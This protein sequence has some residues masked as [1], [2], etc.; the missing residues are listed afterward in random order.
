[1]LLGLLA[2]VVNIFAPLVVA[3]ALYTQMPAALTVATFNLSFI[4]SKSGQ[5]L[6]FV[7]RDAFDWEIVR[8]AVFSLP[9][10]LAAL[11]GGIRLRRRL[12]TTTY[13]R[14]LRVALWVIALAILVDSAAGLV[15]EVA[16]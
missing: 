10:I 11:W 2:G 12:D 6:G 14:M 3:F 8:L 15:F 4:T 9:L 5:I 1:M 13:R 16:A 7:S